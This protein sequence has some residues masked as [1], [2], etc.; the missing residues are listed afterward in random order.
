MTFK[1]VAWIGN[2]TIVFAAEDNLWT[3]PA[4]CG[5][6]GTPCQFPRDATRLT[7]DGTA[8]APDV[9]PSWTSSTATL[10]VASGGGTAATGGGATGGGAPAGAPAKAPKGGGAGR[11][12][13]AG[14]TLSGLAARRAKLAFTLAAGSN[15]APLEK[16]AVRLSQGLGF[17]RVRRRLLAGISLRG[18]GAKRLKFTAAVGHG[19]LTITLKKPASEVEVAIGRPTITVSR[20]LAGKVDAG[21]NVKLRVLVTATDTAKTTTHLTLSPKVM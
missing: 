6:G 21:K 10:G 4:S 11:P 12:Q 9:E 17:S 7:S 13:V 18:A 3:I 19:V 1:D 16:I 15:S 2:S 20:A 8:A 14:A 5:S